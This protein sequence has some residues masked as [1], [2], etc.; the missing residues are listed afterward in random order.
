MLVNSEKGD[1]T[2]QAINM[3]EQYAKDNHLTEKD[4][5]HLR[6]IVE[7]TAEIAGNLSEGKEGSLSIERAKKGSIIRLLIKENSLSEEKYLSE[8]PSFGVM[9]N[10]SLILNLSYEA[11]EADETKLTCIGVR[12]ADKRDLTEMGVASEGEAYVWTGEGYNSLSFDR[13]NQNDDT[14]WIEIS[15]SIIANLSDDVRVVVFRDHSELTI[16]VPFTETGKSKTEKYAV[17][18]ELKELYKIPVAK[19]GFQIRMVQLLYSRLPDKQT[20]TDKLDVIK[21][22]I[23]CA[24]APK[25]YINILRYTPAGRTEEITPAVLFMHGGAF[26]LPALPYHYRLAERTA[27]KTG[28]SVFFTLQDLGP[29]HPLP[30]PIKEAYE[31][32]RYLIKNSGE[33]KIDPARIVAMGD[34]SG[35]TMTAALSMLARDDDTPLAGQV[36]LYPSIGL[37]YETQSMKSFTDVP[38]VNAEAIKAYHKMLKTGDDADKYYLHPASA[39]LEKLPAAYV[40]TAEFDALRDEGI[41]YAGMLREN[42]CDVVLNKTKGTVHA[43]DMAKDSRVLAEAMDRRMEFINSVFKK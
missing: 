37:D 13:M 28:S 41:I 27:I 11:I 32:Y 40:E 7:E 1:G 19:T 5:L 29:R 39:S 25:G 33:L 9:S 20:S 17:D 4:G 12:K 36:L 16:H 15:H 26:M 21:I 34:S 38:V 14:D 24:S 18:P 30:L 2:K 35:G 6:L 3:A 23:P 10:I 22:K 42:G 31:V 8:R 43:Y